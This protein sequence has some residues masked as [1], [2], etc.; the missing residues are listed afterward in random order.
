MARRFKRTAART[1]QHQVETLGSQSGAKFVRS[2]NTRRCQ[3]DIAPTRVAPVDTPLGLCMSYQP[4]LFRSGGHGFSVHITLR[5]TRAFRAWD[6][7]TTD[8]RPQVISQRSGRLLTLTLNDPHRRNALGTALFDQLEAALDTVTPRV[9][10]DAPSVIVLGAHGSAFC[11][12]F[13][14]EACVQD[15]DLLPIFVERLGQLTTRIRA[16]PAVVIAQVQGAALAGGCALAM[17]CDIVH[18]AADATFG[19]PVHRIGVSPAVNI[20]MLLATAGLGGARRIALSG[21]IIQASQAKSLGMVQDVHADEHTLR[22]AVATLAESLCVKNPHA[23]RTT[24]DWLNRVDGTDPTGSL[25]SAAGRAAQ[26]TIDVCRT[27][28]ARIMLES[29]W[30]QRRSRP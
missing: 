29:F 28:E 27:T 21:E 4:N 14:L 25:G 1:R 30:S 6:L 12:G 10:D 23:L 18:A 13:D 15:P 16:L 11:A 2:C 20:P 26:A 24:K 5:T 19:Y 22:S 8:Q 7:M 9:T 3:C 17:S